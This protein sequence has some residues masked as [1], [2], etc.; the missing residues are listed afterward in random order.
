MKRD[1]DVGVSLGKRIEGS[2]EAAEDLAEVSK[3]LELPSSSQCFL[4]PE[5]NMVKIL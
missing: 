1:S 3:L 5:T 2:Q 4:Q